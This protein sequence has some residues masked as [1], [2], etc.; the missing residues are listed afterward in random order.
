MQP[1]DPATA[2]HALLMLLPPTV[3]PW[4][5]ALISLVFIA[6]TIVGLTK[7]R[8]TW[9]AKALWYLSGLVHSDQ[10]GTIK[11]PGTSIVIGVTATN[12]PPSP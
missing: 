2:I 10:P 4:V 5:Q 12:T 8:D 1:L 3:Q 9:W 7:R 6:T 11:I